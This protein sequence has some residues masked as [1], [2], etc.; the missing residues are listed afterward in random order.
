MELLLGRST[1]LIFSCI[2]KKC[3]HCVPG[4]LSEN[5]F[6][7]HN[8]GFKVSCYVSCGWTR[9]HQ[10][11]GWKHTVSGWTSLKDFPLNSIGWCASDESFR[12][13]SSA[14]S[15][16]FTMSLQAIIQIRL[17]KMKASVTCDDS[18]QLSKPSHTFADL[19]KNQPKTHVPKLS[20]TPLLFRP[21]P[22]WVKTTMTQL[23]ATQ[24]SHCS[25]MSE[26]EIDLKILRRPRLEQKGLL[27]WLY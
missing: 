21:M 24:L 22:N 16:D 4:L 27:C 5:T 23:A 3:Q 1:A 13:R 6:K 14:L 12:T 11:T 18:V 8:E 25:I 26:N 10:T 19:A 2:K 17:T 7:T 9:K 15:K 20:T